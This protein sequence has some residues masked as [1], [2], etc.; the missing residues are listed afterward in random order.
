MVQFYCVTPSAIIKI[1]TYPRT[2]DTTVDT[3]QIPFY[4]F[5][6]FWSNMTIIKEFDDNGL[7]GQAEKTDSFEINIKSQFL[8][9][10]LLPSCCTPQRILYLT[11][12]L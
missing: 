4:I 8:F 5:N 3:S 1:K 11:L 12:T 2:I 7:K 10:F 6:M 9:A